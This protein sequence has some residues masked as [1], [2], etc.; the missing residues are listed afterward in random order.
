M[1]ILPVQLKKLDHDNR[2]CG[3]DGSLNSNIRNQQTNRYPWPLSFLW[4]ILARD[5]QVCPSE[6]FYAYADRSIVVVVGLTEESDFDEIDIRSSR[7]LDQRIQ[8]ADVSYHSYLIEIKPIE[9]I[10]ITAIGN[11]NWQIF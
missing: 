2:H 1:G 7:G 4:I 5:G 9:D 3:R 6:I 11:P 10:R 8:I